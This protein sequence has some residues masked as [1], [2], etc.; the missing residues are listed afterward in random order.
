MILQPWCSIT[1][2]SHIKQDKTINLLILI[3]LNLNFIIFDIE[4]RRHIK[5]NL[6]FLKN[7]YLF[8]PLNNLY[9]GRIKVIASIEEPIVIKKI[10]RCLNSILAFSISKTESNFTDFNINKIR[11]FHQTKGRNTIFRPQSPKAL[12]H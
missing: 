10:P 11:Y 12:K 1:A 4:Y 8:L 2:R 5:N 6:V 3:T 9:A 7:R